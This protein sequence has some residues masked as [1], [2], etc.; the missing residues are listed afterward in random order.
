M[1]L[2]NAIT[3]LLL[4][5]CLFISCDRGL[6]EDNTSD[7]PT[8][9]ENNSPSLFTKLSPDHTQ[10]KFVNS[11]KEFSHIN[12]Y[13]YINVYNGSGVSIGDINNDGLLD[14]YL[15]GNL[16][17]NRLYL[18]QGNMVFK[19]ITGSARVA[20]K[21]GWNTGTTMVDINNDGFL[22]IY[23]CRA[24]NDHYPKENKN[25]LF[26]NNG[27]LTFTEMGKKYGIND[28]RNATQ[29]TFFDYDRDGDLDLY[30]GNH[31]REYS[32]KV[33]FNLAKWMDPKLEE[34]DILYRNNG[35]NTF[36]DVTIEA[37]ILNYGFLLGV[38]ASDIN[39]DGWTDIY[40]GNDHSEP[41]RYYVNQGDGTFKDEIDQAFKHISNFSM[42]TD[43]ADFNN[44]GLLDIVVVDMM[45]E[46]NY[47]QK[48]QMS[49]MATEIFWFFVN[50]GYHYQ[51]M[52]NV[53]Q[54]NN[55]NGRFSEIG[56]MAGI[57]TTDW[58]WAVLMADFDN[59]GYK[60]LFV[61]NGYRKNYR[62]NDYKIKKEKIMQ[63]A[64]LSGT[65]VD[66][67]TLTK[68]LSSTKLRNY[69]FKNNGDL[70]F[71]D[72]TTE[73]GFD[74]LTFSNGASYGDLDNDG[75]LDIVI[76]NLDDPVSIF[77][78]NSFDSPGHNYIRFK[79]EGAELNPNGLGTKVTIYTPEGRQY[80]E[81][82]L[83]RGFMS[84][85]EPALHFGLGKTDLVDSVKVIWPDGKT[86][87]LGPTSANQH[88]VL[89]YK[90]A[91]DS[92]SE[93]TTSKT[94]MSAVDLGID[95][96]HVENI[97]DDYFKEI[98]L[99]HQMSRFG[100]NISV[101]D[102]NGDNLDD[103]FVG[104]AIEQ[105]GS[106][107]I[108][109]ASGTF[110]KKN[111]PVFE[112]DKNHEDLGSLLFDADGDGDMDLYVV[113][114][115]N[116]YP[117]NGRLLQDRLYTGDGQGNFA[118]DNSLLPIMLT[119][120]SCV[121]PGDLDGDGDLDLF[122]GG[123]VVPGRYPVAPRSYILQNNK[124]SFTD[125]TAEVAP[126]LV[127]P[128][129]VTTA[130]WTD[131]DNDGK[132]DLM[133]SGEWMPIKIFINK[134][135]KLQDRSVDYGLENTTG[136]WFKLIQCDFDDDGDMD[137]VAGNLGLNY[138]YK[139]SIEEPFHVYS[140]DFDENGHLDIVLGYYNQGDCFPV[141]GRQCSSDQIPDIK[142]KFLNYK[143]FGNATL[144]DVYG[145]KLNDALHYEATQFAS[146]Y[147]ENDGNG[148]L[149][150]S[151]L[152]NE[153]QISVVMGMVPFDV[154]NNGLL[155]L[156]LAGNFY[157]S[158][159]ET[160]RADAGI[161]LVLLGDGSGKLQPIPAYESGID[162]HLDVRDLVI[163]EK[164]ASGTPII[165]VANNDNVLQ[166]FKL[167]AASRTTLASR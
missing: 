10:V 122:V 112:Q 40:V 144:A 29:A 45:A 104:G 69:Y 22:D 141:R 62:D 66:V 145:D 41:D 3:P 108:Q 81:A 61:S 134:D 15:T 94:L 93:T 48:T 70:T 162:A 80:A 165:L 35:D 76:N 157:V 85:V 67:Q 26:V 4:V 91:E 126:D 87:M 75:D 55:G 39:N 131:I 161:G 101:G 136:W 30:V 107:Y 109:T 36:T 137:Y 86:F 119:S 54:L 68:M 56:Q 82:T 99:P 113:S 102:V 146:S 115:G 25:Q 118:G 57:S 17:G 83:T 31:P 151:P 135:G 156:I 158:E 95:Y 89:N 20:S 98:L 42:G 130:L 13:N 78:N 8:S 73:F 152:P 52:R 50:N 150:L 60:D 90:E 124:G 77:Q 84:S 59:D 138:K 14:I 164:T 7:T 63:K 23:V 100:P 28:P 79:L 88:L 11:L 103:F 18:N 120:G 47:R 167:N 51:Y 38:V 43:I 16:I 140:H 166:S 92:K 123:R 21:N 1:Q 2:P 44:D 163:I 160:G 153:A 159:V 34:S 53:L 19:D 149:I 142:N 128:G 65:T 74:E 116:E 155:D 147:L 133:V 49:P 110:V 33:E 111:I 129:L 9:V 125:I 105:S 46:D 139:A 71:S 154:D 72:R 96:R 12:H 97:Y 148:H 121:V 32:T 143:S 5:A 106:L 132:I 64:K 6:V 27:D 117:P 24:F 127:K 114:G 58:S 37:G